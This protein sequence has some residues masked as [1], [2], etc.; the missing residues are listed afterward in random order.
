MPAC[1]KMQRVEKMS[2]I[3]TP[4]HVVECSGSKEYAYLISLNEKK[5]YRRSWLHAEGV[6]DED[7]IDSVNST[8]PSLP[9]L[10]NYFTGKL[11]KKLS[12]YYLDKHIIGIEDEIVLDI[13]DA[14]FLQRVSPR[15]K[16]FDMV[17]FYGSQSRTF[18]VVDK[19]DLDTIRSWFPNKIFS[20]GADPL[21][22]KR[23]CTWLSENKDSKTKYDDIY[24][25][26]FQQED[27]TCSEY[28][29]ES[30]DESEDESCVDSHDS[31]SESDLES[32]LESDVSDDDYEPP[33]KRTKL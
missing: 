20:C 8:L 1:C 3:A 4:T 30:E 22:L 14:I 12:E 18:G 5:Y 33:A 24:E 6:E 32:D 19:S 26:M 16:T 29:P 7:K 9:V 27:S 11:N 2:D 25:S 31:M 10:E 21:P 13:P 23:I 15:T 28:E 17:F